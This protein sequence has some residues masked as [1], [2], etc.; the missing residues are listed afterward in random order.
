[1]LD[2]PLGQLNDVNWDLSKLWSQQTANDLRRT[3]KDTHCECTW[4]C[5]QADNVLFNPRSWPALLSGTFGLPSRA[6][7][8]KLSRPPANEP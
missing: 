3:I 4:E 8:P 7:G 6:P 1:M 5:A 2:Q